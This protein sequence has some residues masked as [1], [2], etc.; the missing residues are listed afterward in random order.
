MTGESFQ[1]R[2]SRSWRKG[3]A[4][5]LRSSFAESFPIPMYSF[6]KGVYTTFDFA[7]NR[8]G[9]SQLA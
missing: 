8:V 1:S 2:E 6:L 4:E 3:G 5:L 9:F 7:N